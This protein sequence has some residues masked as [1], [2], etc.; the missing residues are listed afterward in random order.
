MNAHDTITGF[1]SIGVR[2]ST[3]KRW[4]K[5]NFLAR[6]LMVDNEMP[7]GPVSRMKGTEL[8]RRI[9]LCM[10][11]V[12]AEFGDSRRFWR[13]SPFS[14]TINCRRNRRL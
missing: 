11:T 2:V 3:F 4:L 12:V 13:Q 8:P 5:S 7:S 14:A 1:I 9:R 6:V 10:Y